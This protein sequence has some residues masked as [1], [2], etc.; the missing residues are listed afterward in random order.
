MMSGKEENIEIT[1]EENK[2][3]M[4]Q[5]RRLATKMLIDDI[6]RLRTK[7][8]VVAEPFIELKI[9]MN[10][11][12]ERVIPILQDYNKLQLLEEAHSTTIAKLRRENETLREFRDSIKKKEESDKKEAE[13]TDKGG[14]QI[15]RGDSKG[16][17]S[18]KE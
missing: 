17:K 10:T 5:E 7:T 3:K 12:A 16:D 11:F 13:K 2:E 4:K 9:A 15:V 6:N 8:D 14:E 1:E 18:T